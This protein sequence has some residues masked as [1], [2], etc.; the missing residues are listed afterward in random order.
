M[1]R[2]LLFCVLLFAAAELQAASHVEGTVYLKGGRTVTYTQNDRLEIPRKAKPLYGWRDAFRKTKSRT[3][4][5]YDEID[6][7]V[8]WAPRHPEKRHVFIPTAVGWCRVY[9]ATP[10]LRALL[11]SRKGYT[12]YANGGTAVFVR[13]GVFTSSA[14]TLWLQKLPDGALWTPGRL[15]RSNDD[16]FRRRIAEFVADDPALAERIRRSSTSR[17][18]TVLLL[19]AYRPSSEQP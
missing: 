16:A 8:L 17:D 9:F 7:A 4:Y 12:I 19:D 15:N 14:I 11:H 1:N 5:R 3:V 18:K 13:S 2:F 6:S 10:Q